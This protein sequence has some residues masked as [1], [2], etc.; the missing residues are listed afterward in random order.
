MHTTIKCLAR[1]K[2]FLHEIESILFFGLEN[3]FSVSGLFSF[4]ADIVHSI[5][6]VRMT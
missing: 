3:D 1:V 6:N 4:I 5:L 2:T